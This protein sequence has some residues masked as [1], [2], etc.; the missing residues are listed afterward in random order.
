MS[1]KLLAIRPLE[2]CNPKFLKNL[3]ENRIYKFYNDYEFYIDGIKA[4]DAQ[5]GDIT[6]IKFNQSVPENFFGNDDLKINISAI[7][8]KNGSGKSSLVEL[9]I[10]SIN[11][12]SFQ[13]KNKGE[14]I[15][16]ANLRLAKKTSDKKINCEFFYLKEDNFYVI[17]IK[18]ND[19]ENPE[20]INI[21]GDSN[22]F[23]LKDFFYTEVIN[24]SI[25][26]YNSLEMGVWIDELF[27]KNDAYQIPIVI[28]P[29]RESQVEGW[30]G[31][32]EVN[33]EKYLL[34]QRL[35]SNLLKPIKDN[36]N[37]RKIGDNMIAVKMQ[38]NNKEIRDFF[39]YSNDEEQRGNKYTE[40]N[41]KKE[42][43]NK[44]K[45]NNKFD[46]SVNIDAFNQETPLL[47]CH[48]VFEILNAIKSS[49]ELHDIQDEDLQM[50]LDYYLMYK[51]ISICDKYSE[52]KNFVK[53]NDYEFEERKYKR[54]KIDISKFIEYIKENKSHVTYKLYQ[55]INYIKYYDSFWKNIKLNE[56]LDLEQLSK[57][58]ES[59][60]KDI[61]DF[62]EILP[63]PIFD[64][65]I[66]LDDGK[67]SDLIKLNDLSSGE[68]QL[69]H[70]VSSITYHLNNINSVK[71]KKT[72]K[73]E[74]VNLIFEEIE[75]Y[76]HP[77]YQRKFIDYILK[78]FENTNLKKIKGINILF[79]THSP[80][81]L[82]DIPKQNVL[83]LQTEEREIENEKG[84]KEKKM[85]AI[86]QVYKGD[87]TFGENIHQMLTDGFFITDTKGAFVKSKID[88]F[89]LFYN[90]RYHKSKKD[91]ETRQKYFESLIALIGEDYVR[92]ILTNHLKELKRHFEIEKYETIELENLEKEKRKIEEKINHLK[93]N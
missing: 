40:Y 55:T 37:L 87:N 57:G 21:N 30:P 89:L 14:L 2:D 77:E 86:P 35:L 9:F 81:I 85:L 15:T 88:E 54:Y 44:F 10:V 29:K 63:P 42:L 52:F 90:D 18:E 45:N 79:I 93:G 17:K 24:Y 75:L 12:L 1:F 4:K 62:I 92:R 7:V 16:T 41:E 27:H 53:N 60:N 38:L 5:K 48:N 64:I 80:F 59:L 43:Y 72:I 70:S 91:F 68:Q 73:Y 11:Q 25:Y 23:N 67:N 13:L 46:F 32:I 83:F 28:N 19:F 31:I 39:V 71:G 69:I 49:F 8:G 26:A 50:Q 74:Y 6:E 58:L 47:S 82:S 34:K 84:E 22:I 78:S 56:K 65:E 36:I 76:F 61:E 51:I 3:E 20:Q 66:F 33:N